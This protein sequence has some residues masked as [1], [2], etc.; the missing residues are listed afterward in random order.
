MRTLGAVL[1]GGRASRFGSDKALAP[2]QGKPLILWATEALA[3][4]CDAV[5]ICGRALADHACT[6]DQ[7]EPDLGPLGGVAGALHYAQAH[8]FD[9]VLTAPCDAPHLPAHLLTLLGD[10]PALAAETPVVGLW[11]VALAE[12]LDRFLATDARRSIR[13]WARRVGAR[14][15]PLPPIANVNT[16]ADL[17]GLA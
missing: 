3:A 12:D 15:V 17:A 7:P 1:A 14:A 16:P 11:P 13:D 4:E 10:A 8:G 2:Y 9:Q 6:P 5:V